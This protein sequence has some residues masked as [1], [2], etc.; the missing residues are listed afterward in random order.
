MGWVTR[1]GRRSISLTCLPARP[2]NLTLSAHLLLPPPAPPSLHPCL[3][4][5]RAAI[6]RG[7]RGDIARKEVVNKS[8]AQGEFRLTQK[9]LGVR[10][11]GGGGG[12]RE[13]W[14]TQKHAFVSCQHERPTAEGTAGEDAPL[15]ARLLYFHTRT[16][17]ALQC[18]GAALHHPPQP[19][20]PRR[21]LCQ[22]VSAWGC[23]LGSAVHQ[24]FLAA[25]TAGIP[26]M[27]SCCVCPAPDSRAGLKQS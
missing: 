2:S 25:V 23:L 9:E 7:I 12:G 3:L 20:V 14:G 27:A 18:S 5:V 10:S 6:L 21:A 15:P 19:A 26:T 8:T 13:G 17:H 1:H 22:D 16:C 24:Q 11:R 4:A